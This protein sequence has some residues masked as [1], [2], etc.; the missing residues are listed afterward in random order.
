MAPSVF[1]ISR[2]SKKLKH[3][4]LREIHYQLFNTCLII[5][6]ASW[7][8]CCCYK[9]YGCRLKPMHQ[10]LPGERNYCLIC[11]IRIAYL[12]D[13]I[14]KTGKIADV[15]NTYLKFKVNYKFI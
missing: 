7:K 5:S 14:Y 2:S 11:Q 13:K 1:I 3:M 9:F 8:E 10:S 15:F 12:M 6:C 4:V